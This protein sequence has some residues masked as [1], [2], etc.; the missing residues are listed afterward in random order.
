LY[1]KARK[2]QEEEERQGFAIQEEA[3]KTREVEEHKLAKLRERERK[4]A[5]Y[6]QQDKQ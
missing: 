3:R 4:Q 6:D 1:Y 5:L 2:T